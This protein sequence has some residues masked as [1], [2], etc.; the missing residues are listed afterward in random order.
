MIYIE[1]QAIVTFVKTSTKYIVHSLNEP[2]MGVVVAGLMVSMLVQVRALA[3]VTVKVSTHKG[4]TPC[5]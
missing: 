4:T 1:L 5:D 3:E 2:H